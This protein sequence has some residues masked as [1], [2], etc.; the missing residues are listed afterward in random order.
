MT[1]RHIP[2]LP[3]VTLIHKSLYYRC[4]RF[5]FSK[6]DH[7]RIWSYLHLQIWSEQDFGENYYTYLTTVPKVVQESSRVSPTIQGATQPH[8]KPC[9]TSGFYNPSQTT[10]VPTRYAAVRQVAEH[11]RQRDS[12]VG[13]SLQSA[14]ATG[15][16]SIALSKHV[17]QIC[18]NYLRFLT[19]SDLDLSAFQMKIGTPI[20]W[21]LE[22][23]FTNCDCSTFVVFELWAHTARIDRQADIWEDLLI[24]QPTARLHS[25]ATLT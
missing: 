10:K 9:I 20:T 13:T 25:N 1:L 4:S 5:K 18:G 23:V 16:W 3:A 21:D 2:N 24:M 6:S 7:S 19:S 15:T 12:K 11:L 8:F 14:R 17:R 22:N